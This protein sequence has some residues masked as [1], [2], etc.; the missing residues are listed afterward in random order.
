MSRN[1]STPTKRLT[2]NDVH[3]LTSKVLQEY[4][5][6]DMSSSAY[7]ASDIWD[8][9]VTAAVQQTTVETACGLLERAPSANT[10]RH[11]VKALL[12]DDEQL[13]HLEV[14]VNAMLAA[15]LPK[16]LLRR[17]RPCAVDFT[18]LPYHGQHDADDEHIRRG[19]AK[20]GTTHFHSFTTLCVVKATRR[21]TLALSLHR[22]SDTALDALKRVLDTARTAG[23]RIRRLMLDREFDTNAV[24]GPYASTASF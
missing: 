8:V 20:S 15:R 13:T 14:T 6:L 1:Q 3:E 9:L 5:E 19:R 23:L 4:F 7:E 24:V 10:V 11:A 12:M 18:D 16:N 22:R 2:A 17:A 21:Y